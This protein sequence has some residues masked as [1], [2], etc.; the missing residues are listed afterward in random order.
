MNEQGKFKLA[1][2]L[3]GTGIATAMILATLYPLGWLVTNYTAWFAAGLWG[4]LMV[5]L[6]A[7]DR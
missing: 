7:I 4:T 3:I 2:I 5:V 1:E 6:C